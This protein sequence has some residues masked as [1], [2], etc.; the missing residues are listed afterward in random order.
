MASRTT[1]VHCKPVPGAHKDRRNDE[2][3]RRGK[4]TGSVRTFS[5]TLKT[6]AA[7][8]AIRRPRQG[9]VSACGWSAVIAR[10]RPRG[11]PWPCLSGRS[12]HRWFQQ[13]CPATQ[14]QSTRWPHD[15]KPRPPRRPRQGIVQKAIRSGTSPWAAKLWKR[16][17]TGKPV[18]D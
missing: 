1:A 5:G 7:R 14:A 9:A 8:S 17:F 4:I 16:S 6:L 11:P 2:W 18:Q 13:E 10:S 15:R 3:E 12:H